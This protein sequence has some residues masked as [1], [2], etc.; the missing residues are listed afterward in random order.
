[1]QSSYLLINGNRTHYLHWNL[2]DGGQPVLLLHGLASN[3]RI[4]QALAPDLV[5]A[6]LVPIAPNARGHGLT[7]KP[8]GSYGL[9]SFLR[10]LAAFIDAAHLERPVLVGHSWG[11]MLALEYAARYSFGARAPAKLVL[12]DGGFTQMDQIPGANWE[13]TRQ[14]LTPPKLAG[15][16]VES[17]LS[18]LAHPS[19]K[20]QPHDEAVQAILANFEISTDELIYPRLSLEH[21]MEIL[22][23]IW[24]FQTYERFTRL[25]CPVL[26]VPAS[27]PGPLDADDRVHLELKQQGISKAQAS[28]KDL[29][30]RWM[31]DTIHDIPL[32]R[33]AELARLIVDFALK[34]SDRG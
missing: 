32:Q 27:P 14:R 13:Q 4:W 10:D 29:R 7:D 26:M 12:V 30:V 15:T 24:E 3:A 8:G 25:R 23:S 18:M 33:P 5:S 1:M 31:E 20:W 2:E 34:D 17:F 21:H 16:S 28:I 19:Q 22:R 6:G 11:G 9:D